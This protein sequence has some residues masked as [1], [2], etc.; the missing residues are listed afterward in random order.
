[1]QFDWI[2]FIIGSFID[3]VGTQALGKNSPLY[4]PFVVA[5]ISLVS[6]VSG[7]WFQHYLQMR[8]LRHESKSY[9]SKI[10]YDKQIEFLDALTPLLDQINEYITTIDVWLG[11]KG[12]KAED[13]V[14][15]AVQNNSCLWDLDQ[16]LQKYYFFLPSKLLKIIKN[17]GGECHL[18]YSKPD[19]NKT[20]QCIELLFQ[21]TND[22]RE[23][24]G[25]DRLSEDLMRAMGR[26]KDF[27]NS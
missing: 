14:Q 4:S 17:L 16:L 6:A 26:K 25:V 21:T 13:K 3:I 8:K 22:V 11:E 7:F 23:Y 5:L 24:V 9:P 15:E 18:L 12:K 27:Q 19:T 10:L 2:P 1:M 20:Y